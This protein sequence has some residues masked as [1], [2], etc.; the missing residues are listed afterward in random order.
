[1]VASKRM[2]ITRRFPAFLLAVVSAAASAQ[3]VIDTPRTSVEAVVGQPCTID[4]AVH[5]DGAAGAYAIYPPDGFQLDWGKVA[6]VQTEAVQEEGRATVRHRIS[7][8]SSKEGTY[9][10]PALS[11]RYAAPQR[12]M[13]AANTAPLPAVKSE[14]VTVAV[15]G[16][17]NPANAA[18]WVGAAVLTALI[19][20]AFLLRR[21]QRRP[22]QQAPLSRAEAVQQSLHAARRCRLD[23]DF[24]GYYQA[25]AEAARRMAGDAEADR[26]A[27]VM[28]GRA[29]QVGYQGARPTEDQLDGDQRDVERAFARCKE[30]L[31]S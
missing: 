8:T 18:V 24:Y 11:V 23:G 16:G 12:V 30:A 3:P 2:N 14:P 22:Q 1:M 27:E 6:D 4:Y 28:Q 7:V 26:L 21:R 17:G 20:L 9:E 19:L 5:W 15:R 29:R 25:L 31:R 13:D 10:I